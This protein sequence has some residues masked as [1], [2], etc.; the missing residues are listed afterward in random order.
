MRLFPTASPLQTLELPGLTFAYTSVTGLDITPEDLAAYARQAGMDVQR[1]APLRVILSQGDC[2]LRVTFEPTVEELAQATVTAALLHSGELSHPEG[3][4]ITAPDLVDV[5][6]DANWQVR[7]G[8]V[9]LVDI[10]TRLLL[11]RVGVHAD[12]SELSVALDE[13]PAVLDLARRVIAATN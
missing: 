10:A 1:P 4:D 7:E 5:L 13:T 12:R 11:D 9:Q 6:L 8:S 2:A 3:L